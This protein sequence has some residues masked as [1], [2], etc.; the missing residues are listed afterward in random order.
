MGGALDEG[1]AAV[2]DDDDLLRLVIHVHV[3]DGPVGVNHV[4]LHI[5]LRAV[6]P[7]SL[8]VNVAAAINEDQARNCLQTHKVSQSDHSSFKTSKSNLHLT[9]TGRL[10]FP[11]ASA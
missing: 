11:I 8:K 1:L 3:V 5:V 2:V 4:R 10:R 6:E 7:F 9:W